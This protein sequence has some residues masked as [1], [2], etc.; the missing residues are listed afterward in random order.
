MSSTLPGRETRFTAR[1]REPEDQASAYTN[2]VL[3]LHGK[4]RA[5]KFRSQVIDSSS[6]CES[7]GNVVFDSGTYRPGKARLPSAVKQV[8]HRNRAV[9][10]THAGE[11]TNK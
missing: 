4:I 3:R 2:V 1:S 11:G 7:R 10:Q 8:T 9:H 6:K 5:Y